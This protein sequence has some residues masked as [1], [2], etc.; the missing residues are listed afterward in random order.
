MKNK[1]KNIFISLL[2]YIVIA[3]GFLIYDYEKTQMINWN[4]VFMCMVYICTFLL[5]SLLLIVFDKKEK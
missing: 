4:F 5:T 1:S 3:F 2:V